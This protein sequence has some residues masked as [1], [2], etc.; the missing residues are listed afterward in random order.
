MGSSFSMERRDKLSL[1]S[2]IAFGCIG[3]IESNNYKTGKYNPDNAISKKRVYTMGFLNPSALVNPYSDGLFGALN[4]NF[5]FRNDHFSDSFKNFNQIV[6]SLS[7]GANDWDFN[8]YNDGTPFDFLGLGDAKDRYWTGGGFVSIDFKNKYDNPLESK[9]EI[10]KAIIG[11]DRFTGYFPHAFE[12][13]NKLGLNDVPYENPKESFYNKGRFYLGSEFATMPGFIPM[14][15]FRDNNALDVQR[16][17][18]LAGGMPY[19]KTLLKSSWAF[20]TYYN[21]QENIK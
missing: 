19:H 9:N 4:V 7:I 13:A 14:I 6:G 12:V 10:R 20:D 18:H 1:E 11:F 3:S 15:N 2:R 17:I 21:F 8:Y 16:W 5:V